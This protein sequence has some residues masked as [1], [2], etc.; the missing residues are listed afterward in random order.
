MP[1]PAGAIPLAMSIAKS[2][3]AQIAANAA[4]NAIGAIVQAARNG[5]DISSLA[6]LSRPARV[7]PLVLVEQTLQNQPFMENVMKFGLTNFAAYYLQAFSMLMNVGRIET[8]KVFDS[9]NP[10]RNFGMGQGALLQGTVLSQE[11]F[12]LGLPSLEAYDRPV[13]PGLIASL[14]SFD[15]VSGTAKIEKLYEVES[16]S[17]GKLVNVELKDGDQI[18]KIPVLIRLQATTVKTDIMTHIFTAG[19]RDSYGERF[20]LARAGLI[21]PIRDLI[22]GIDLIDEH[23]RAL[24]NDNS[25][26]YKAI[27][28]RRR[29][30]VKKAAMSGV[31]SAADASNIAVITKETAKA[32]G[33]K[34]YGKL[35]NQ[36][37]RNRIFD[38]SY[39]LLLIVVDERYEQI[40]VYHR[41]L[42]IASEHS[43]KEIAS[44]E[45]GRGQDI[46]E[47]YKMI[48]GA[49]GSNV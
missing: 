4:S 39:L 16:L 25:G 22:F 28:D 19:G 41:G 29:N 33:Q 6:D 7:E 13:V 17:V 20:Q 12:D 14:E 48:L 18:S 32:I 38:N 11:E 36:A 44:A 37:V 34:L 26:A 21:R 1:L 47:V 31:V 40:T 2:T 3:G 8:L 42:D 15:E 35:D 9:L 30:N 27:T 5:T 24:M 43:F 23:R 45:K 10:N 46:T 49:M